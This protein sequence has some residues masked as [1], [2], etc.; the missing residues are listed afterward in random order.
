MGVLGAGDVK[1]AAASGAWL[2][3][4]GVVEASLI[5]A[6]VGG[7]LAAWALARKGGITAGAARFGAWLF[8]SR[9]TNRLAPELTPREQRVPYGVAIA[10]GA[11]LVAWVPGL[12]W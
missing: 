3:V 10:A 11:A 5:A 6:V 1:L 7:L 9:V 12:I 4:S 8:A 2:G